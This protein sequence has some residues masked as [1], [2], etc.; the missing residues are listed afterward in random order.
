MH[1]ALSSKISEEAN[2]KLITMPDKAEVR[3]VV[4]SIHLDKAPGPDGFSASFYQV[5]RD[6]I[7]DDIYKDI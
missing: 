6:I 2:R 5:F 1:E 7:G 4:F 3:A